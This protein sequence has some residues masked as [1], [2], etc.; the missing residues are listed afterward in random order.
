MELSPLHRFFNVIIRLKIIFSTRAR[1][2]NISIS[3][4]ENDRKEEK[5]ENDTP[6]LLITF[7][8]SNLLVQGL[9]IS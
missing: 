3:F 1:N 8:T 7:F 9:Q 4:S 6:S 5:Y 2:H